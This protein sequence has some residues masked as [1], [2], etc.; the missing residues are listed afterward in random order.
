MVYFKNITLNEV[1]W[2]FLVLGS[3]CL[4]FVSCYGDETENRNT[5]V[6]LVNSI[7]DPK[8]KLAQKAIGTG[9]FEKAKE[10][11]FAIKQEID[12]NPDSS[13]YQYVYAHLG[14]LYY[15]SQVIDS[16]IFIGER[17]SD[18]RG[19][20]ESIKMLQPIFRIWVLPT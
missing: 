14:V 6:E 10:I 4:V 18:T 9:E 11:L 3:F 17:P 5:N 2:L 7:Y 8:I 15:Q 19:A 13:E 1:K 12:Q 20:I 16:A